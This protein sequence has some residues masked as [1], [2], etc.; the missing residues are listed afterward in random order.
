LRPW[1]RTGLFFGVAIVFVF[2]LGWYR[3]GISDA[4]FS[5]NYPAQGTRAG[6]VGAMGKEGVVVVNLAN[7]GLIKRLV[8]PN[9]VNLSSH[10]LRN[11]GDRPRRVSIEMS[12][13]P[14]P[15]RWDS[16]ERT[17]NETSH[18]IGRSLAPSSTATVDW[19]ITLPDKL[20]AADT[21]VDARIVVRD[22]ETGEQ[23]TVLPLKIVTTAAAA[24]KAVA[25]AKAGDS[26]G[27]Q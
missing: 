14:Y 15:V 13:M 23:L 1:I 16:T 6:G 25:D 12:G 3:A 7:T 27:G 10:W 8:Q 18:A 24:K 26:R 22:S 2:A 17:W 19:F 9:V 4:D 11:V 21:I 5:L 20:P